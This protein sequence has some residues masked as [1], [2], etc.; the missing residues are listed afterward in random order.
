[1]IITAMRLRSR[2]RILIAM[3]H[4]FFDFRSLPKAGRQL[5]IT[6]CIW[7][8]TRKMCGISHIGL[9]LRLIFVTYVEC[10]YVFSF[11]IDAYLAVAVLSRLKPVL[12]VS[13]LGMTM[14]GSSWPLGGAMKAIFAINIFIFGV[15]DCVSCLCYS[16]K[17]FFYFLCER[18][19]WS[20]T[21]LESA[22]EFNCFFIFFSPSPASSRDPRG[23]GHLFIR[24]GFWHKQ[25]RT[26]LT[27]WS[28]NSKLASMSI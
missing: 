5:Y 2:V 1:M 14:R 19:H 12:L 27:P 16:K 13:M 21:H 28:T 26:R 20:D 9:I 8:T 17:M 3:K 11:W 4:G 24:G 23:Y 6:N 25:T 22:L 7:L 10:S 18:E 15:G